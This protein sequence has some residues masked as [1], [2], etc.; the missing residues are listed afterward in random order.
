M[1]KSIQTDWRKVHDSTSSS[2]TK[3]IFDPELLTHEPTGIDTEKMHLDLHLN[4]HSMAE[5][6]L[7]DDTKVLSLWDTGSSVNLLS[8]ELIKRSPYLSQLPLR[9]CPDYTIS[10]ASSTPVKADTFI[11]FCLKLK[12]GHYLQSTALVVPDFGNVK[13]IISN[14]TMSKMETVID[15]ASCKLKIR[16]KSF[17]FKTTHEIKIKPQEAQV[18]SV[19]STLPRPLKSGSYTCRP[20]RPFSNLL[21]SMFQLQF[22]CNNS[23]LRLCNT[24]SSTVKIKPG[25]PIGYL[26]VDFWQSNSFPVC[27]LHQDL[28]GSVAFC[29]GSNSD[30]CNAMSGQSQNDSNNSTCNS[31]STFYVPNE[32]AALAH[33]KKD[34]E[35]ENTMRMYYE[36]DQDKMTPSDIKQLKLKTF[37]FLSKNDIRLTMTDR[38]IIERELDL[39][40]DSVLTDADRSSVRQFFYEHRQCL[41]TH[42]QPGI[43]NKKCV[44]LKPVNLKPFYIRP[45]LTNQREVEFADR[46]LT[47]LEKMGIVEKT[48]GSE[49][50]SPII[51]VPKSHSGA[52]LGTDK[53]MR[54]VVDFKYLNNHLPQ[55]RFSYPD[56]KYVLQKIGAS[57]ATVFSVL[58]LK[59]AFFSIALDP[60]SRPYTATCAGPGFRTMV[61]RKMAQGLRPSPMFFTDLMN[62]LVSE[63]PEDVRRYIQVIMDD[64]IIFTNDVKTH[65]HVLSAF[66]KKLKEYGLLLTVNKI[67]CF[68]HTVKYMGLTVSHKD[69]S[70]VITPL[71]SR[72]KAIKLLP[73]PRTLRGLK[74]IIG[75]FTYLTRFMKGL[76]KLIQPLHDIVKECNKM[77][78]LEKI[79]PLPDYAKGKGRSKKRSPDITSLWTDVH[80]KCFEEAKELACKSPILVLPNQYDKFVLECDTSKHHCSSILFQMQNGQQ[81]V[82]AYFSA[83]MP[84]SASRF[85][86]SELELHGLVK[87]VKHF[88]YLL[89]YNKF[90]VQ[91]DH[92]AIRRIYCSKGQPKTNRIQKYLEELSPFSMDIVHQSGTKMYL[93]D[94]LSRQA[95]STNEEPIPFLTSESMTGLEYMA[96]LDKE[97]AWNHNKCIGKCSQHAFPL[98]RAEAKRLNVQVPDLFKPVRNTQQTNS[99]VKSSAQ[100][101]VS[102]PTKRRGRPPKQ[103]APPAALPTQQSPTPIDVHDSPSQVSEVI[104]QPRRRQSSPIISR[105]TSVDRE[106]IRNAQEKKRL[107]NMTAIRTVQDTIQNEQL[108]PERSLAKQLH[109]RQSSTTND[110]LLPEVTEDCQQPNIAEQFP[111]LQPLLTGPT[112]K[113]VMK[114]RKGLPSQEAIN[115][116]LDVL[117]TKTMHYY[118]LPFNL[119][120]LRQQQREDPYLRKIIGYLESNIL[121]KKSTHQRSIIAQAENYVLF[122]DLLFRVVNRSRKGLEPK[123]TVCI[124]ENLAHRVFEQYHSGLLTSHTGLTKTYYKI[125]N[126]YYIFNLYKHLYN[127]IMSCRVCS[128]RRDIPFNEKQRDWAKSYIHDFIPM[129]SLSM[130]IKVMPESLRHYHYLLVLKCNSSNYVITEPMKDRK[131][132]T[133]VEAI[134]QRVITTFGP[135]VKNIYCDLDSAFKSSLMQAFAQTLGIDVKFCSTTSH[136]SNSAERSIKSISNL[137]VYYISKYGNK[138]CLFHSAA[139][140]S[141]NTFPIYHMDNYTPYQ[142]VF[143]RETPQ[144]TA[145]SA[146]AE[147]VTQPVSYNYKD[148]MALMTDRLRSIRDN[149]KELHNKAVLE[150]QLQHGSDIENSSVSLCEGDI[151]YIFFPSKTTLSNVKIGSRRL[152]MTYTGPFYIYCRVDKYMYI[153]ST[154]QDEIIEQPFHYSRMKRGLLRI[155]NNKVVKNIFDYKAMIKQQSGNQSKLDE[156][157]VNSEKNSA[158]KVETANIAQADVPAEHGNVISAIVNSDIL[159]PLS[160]KSPLY[161]V[162]SQSGTD[163][164]TSVTNS[165]DL[166][167]EHASFA[168][169]SLPEYCTP[170]KARLKYGQLQIF[171][172]MPEN[173]GYHDQ[174]MFIPPALE[175]DMIKRLHKLKINITGSI[176]NYVKQLYGYM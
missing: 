24:T 32:N 163:L 3:D 130:D 176:Q 74:S 65:V 27:H 159:S 89:K 68:R 165:S 94:M 54:V 169:E 107:D 146:E 120:E 56:L 44:T 14:V 21:P 22:K 148:Y 60:K 46:E 49:F 82:V 133:V 57:K 121:P 85:S 122:S 134:Y 33:D 34:I 135:I 37:P 79:A 17:V 64:C 23:K 112:D 160:Y 36:H 7:I 87:S 50:M 29:M 141:L 15:V 103:K 106:V 167:V 115:K 67:H 28:D 108:M 59:N 175:N 72:I 172:H 9:K 173:K 78:A 104:I 132:Q 39:S 45:Y 162:Q 164:Y 139:A 48:F 43:S 42:G 83:K 117:N 102:K 127:Y 157:T 70:V 109:D 47:K 114:S 171:A 111:S 12:E 90:L 35:L 161:T 166:G 13:L 18:F 20:F 58:D 41:S 2:Y 156:L 53:Q 10:N 16:K 144:V 40:T 25:T 145:L 92:S 113:L 69:G 155:G 138:W 158:T 6:R 30:Q 96:L 1:F 119:A 149:A 97:C 137:L 11:E 110:A 154:L 168:C 84:E 86:A 93:S 126:D 66:L 52:K 95:G 51:L 62:D 136:M 118:K 124:P 129:E 80:T 128:Q 143:V 131:S 100:T 147:K 98:T 8:E 81:R 4:K 150:R 71:G 61:F 88:A 31:T 63:L 105:Q 125:R 76:S 140:Y 38:M 77:K 142:L 91:M 73:I 116:I 5:F 151:V 153:V 19:K 174:W 170:T 123:T 99:N 55:T 101:T 26:M 152:H 75:S